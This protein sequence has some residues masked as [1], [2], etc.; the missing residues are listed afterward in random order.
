MVAGTIDMALEFHAI[1]SNLENPGDDQREDEPSE[2][3][4]YVDLKKPFRG[5]ECG[6]QDRA[7]FDENPRNQRISGCD[8]EHI[9]SS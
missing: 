7:G 8:T 5:T 6:Q 1:R 3:Q 2:Y 4:D 9:A